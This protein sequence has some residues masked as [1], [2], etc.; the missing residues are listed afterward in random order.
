M[1]MQACTLGS[2][3]AGIKKEPRQYKAQPFSIQ[4]IRFFIIRRYMALMSRE[5]Y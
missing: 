3:P 1:C 4:Y 2:L 5:L